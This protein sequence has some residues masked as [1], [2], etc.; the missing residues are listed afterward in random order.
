MDGPPVRSLQREGTRTS[1]GQQNSALG[2]IGIQ[3]GRVGMRG[4]RVSGWP[5]AV[6]GACVRVLTGISG[7]CPH[8]RDSL[9]FWL[10]PCCTA[11]SNR[12]WAVV[13]ESS[14]AGRRRSRRRWPSSCVSASGARWSRAT[15]SPSAAR[16]A[17]SHCLG[18]PLMGTSG[19]SALYVR[20]E[21]RVMSDTFFFPSA[22][23][24][25]LP[26]LMR[27]CVRAATPWCR[28]QA[29]RLARHGLPV[30]R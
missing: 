10:S 21:E 13:Y 22:Y 1:N 18:T 25:A 16:P 12:S 28:V 26:A 17:A 11:K 30:H 29:C 4:L 15:G 8:M 19:R 5:L 20:G 24:D 3:V 7:T 27:I 9:R 14:S 6:A 23:L 2:Q